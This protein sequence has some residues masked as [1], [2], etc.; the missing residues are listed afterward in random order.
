MK[1]KVVVLTIAAVFSVTGLALA[2]MKAV[3]PVKEVKPAVAPVQAAAPAKAVEE[4]KTV[5]QAKPVLVGNKVCPVSGTAIPA[6]E[7]GTV[8]VEYKGMVYNLCCS[9]CKDQFL[10]DPEKFSKIAQDQAAKEAADAKEA[11]AKPAEPVVEKK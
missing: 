2:K 9:G 1:A 11:A 8:T 3:V 4:A 5:E 10:A 6:K 7:L